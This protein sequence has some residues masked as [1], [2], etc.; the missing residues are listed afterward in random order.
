VSD[1]QFQDAALHELAFLVEDYGFRLVEEEAHVVRYAS[2][3]VMVDAALDPRG[4]VELRISRVDDPDPHATLTLHG[5]VGRASAARAAELLAAQLR[6][7]DAALRGD[8]DFFAR[9]AATQREAAEA[10]TCVLLRSR[11]SAD[12]EVALVGLR[13][14]RPMPA[15]AFGNVT[16]ARGQTFLMA[17]EMR[18]RDV[19]QFSEGRSVFVGPIESAPSHITAAACDVIVDGEPTRQV[20]VSE[21]LPE[22]RKRSAAGD[23]ALSTR[24]DAGVTAEI[25]REHDVRLREM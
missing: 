12:R 23:R 24:T 7:E 15:P 16:R 21:E 19:F 14:T 2:P 17:W 11:A 22:R 5:M 13:G 20:E 8:P 4:E 3:S 1:V 6:D 18:V 25:V 9:L 10:W